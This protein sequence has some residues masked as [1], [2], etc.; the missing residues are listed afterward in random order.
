MP[1]RS[2]LTATSS[3]S[4]VTAKCTWAIEAAATGFSSNAL[5]TCSTGW[6]RSASIV[7]RAAATGKR[8]QAILERCQIVG[9][10]VAQEIGAG[11][12]ALA[13]L[14]EGRAHLL[15]RRGQPLARPALGPLVHERPGQP[16]E[17]QRLGQQLEGKERVVP[18]QRPPDTDHPPT[19]T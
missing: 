5:N 17:R 19:V 6:P 8:R 10:V 12:E 4:V 18:R 1:G 3:P 11:R 13:E 14:D 16:Q 9:D 15:E 2:T 7:A